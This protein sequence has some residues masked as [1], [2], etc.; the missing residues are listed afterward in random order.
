MDALFRVATL[1]IDD[2]YTVCAAQLM[3]N[4]GK[5][6]AMQDAYTAVLHVRV[7]A[8][9]HQRALSPQAAH[10]ARYAVLR[11]YRQQH[12]DAVG[13]QVPLDDLY[14]LVLA[15]LPEDL[16][17]VGPYLVVD[18]LA[19]ILWRERDVALAHPLRVRQAVGLLGH[20]PPPTSRLGFPA[21]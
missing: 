8:E 7:L 12:V 11:R 18:D 17:E 5:A 6:A 3:E 9:Y 10:H 14:P 20:T 19:P 15:E 2:F 4:G 16:P 21:A 13:H 1:D